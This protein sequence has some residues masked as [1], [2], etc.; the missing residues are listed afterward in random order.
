MNTPSFREISVDDLS[1]NPFSKVL[2]QWMLISAGTEK[3]CNTMTA[4][5]TYYGQED[6][7]TVLYGTKGILRIYDD[8][9]YSMK[10]ISSGGEEIVY[11]LDAIQTNDSQTKSG[12]I[13]EFVGCIAAGKQPEIWCKRRYF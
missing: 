8:P 5:W 6:N 3:D 2:K 4:S 11:K 13:D 9:G 1:F 10:F 12:V 7:S